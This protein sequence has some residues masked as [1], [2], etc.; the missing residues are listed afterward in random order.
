MCTQNT[1]PNLF[2]RAHRYHWI[3]TEHPDVRLLYIKKSQTHS[4][5]QDIICWAFK[6]IVISILLHKSTSKCL[7]TQTFQNR[8]MYIFET[9]L[10]YT[11][12]HKLSNSPVFVGVIWCLLR[13]LTVVPNHPMRGNSVP[14]Y[15]CPVKKILASMPLPLSWY[16]QSVN[17]AGRTAAPPHFDTSDLTCYLTV[18]SRH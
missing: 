3:E 17:V 13:I 5:A 18:G 11:A 15:P 10:R 16:Y 8:L 6:K 4:C 1:R 12:F 14:P 7:I 9:L 2:T